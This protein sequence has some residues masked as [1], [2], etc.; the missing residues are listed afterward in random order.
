[1]GYNNRDYDNHILAGALRGYGPGKL[2][3]LSQ[4]IIVEKARDAKFSDAY[5][6]SYGDVRDIITNKQSLKKHEIDLGISHIEMGIPWDKPAPKRLWDKIIEYCSNDV[7]ATEAV[8]NAYKGDYLARQILAE[9]A[10]GTV[11]DTTNQLT[12]KIVFGNN[13][14]PKLVYTDLA[15]GESE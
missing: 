13:R 2:Y 5:S 10:G 3:E 1:M 14:H 15:T 8:F 11:N 12:T 4:R 9:L 6:Y 7:I